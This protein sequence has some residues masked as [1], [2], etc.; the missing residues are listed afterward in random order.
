M[1][2]HN[3]VDRNTN[4]KGNS[5]IDQFPIDLFGVQLGSLSFHNGMSK[6]TQ[7]NDFGPWQALS[8]QSLQGQIDNFCSLLILGANITT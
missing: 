6:F 4:G 7:I 8:N 1:I 3:V 2:A 5:S